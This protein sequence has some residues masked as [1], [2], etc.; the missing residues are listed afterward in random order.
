MLNRSS[1]FHQ[2]RQDFGR[3]QM[4]QTRGRPRKTHRN[5]EK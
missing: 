3:M 2:F 4:F 5:T 1:L